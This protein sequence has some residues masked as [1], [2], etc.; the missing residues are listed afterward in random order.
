VGVLY[1]QARLTAYSRKDYPA[2]AILGVIGELF[3]KKPFR[4]LVAA[5]IAV[6]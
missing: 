5:Q 2:F 6:L 1:S 4:V 3:A